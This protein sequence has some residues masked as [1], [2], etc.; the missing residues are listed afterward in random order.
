MRQVRRMAGGSSGRQ[1]D[2]QRIF[3]LQEDTRSDLSRLGYWEKRIPLT[4]SVSQF[5][6]TDS[7]IFFFFL[8][9]I[10][11]FRHIL[12]RN[13]SPPTPS[14]VSGEDLVGTWYATTYRNSDQSIAPRRAAPSQIM[15]IDLK[16]RALRRGATSTAGRSG[17]GNRGDDE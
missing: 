6:S 3:L 7:W 4:H 16:C 5:P 9:P 2:R 1:T 10:N 17:Q 12:P 11:T 15:F 8:L 13:V 14:I